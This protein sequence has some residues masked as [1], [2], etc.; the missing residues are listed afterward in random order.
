MPQLAV[1]ELGGEYYEDH[2]DFDA[3][4]N[5]NGKNRA[6]TESFRFLSDAIKRK[7]KLK[8]DFPTVQYFIARI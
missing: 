5:V 4:V 7:Q 8:E 2:V 3:S 6:D 1:T